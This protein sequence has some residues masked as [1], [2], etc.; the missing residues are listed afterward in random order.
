ML[1]AV[2]R[3]TAKVNTK[4]RPPGFSKLASLESFLRAWPGGDVLFLNDGPV[5]SASWS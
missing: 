3:S 5:P 4:P 1:H 2:Y